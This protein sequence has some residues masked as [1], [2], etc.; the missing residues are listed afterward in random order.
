MAGPI[1]AETNQ[2]PGNSSTYMGY[3]GRL[4]ATPPYK[5][6]MTDLWAANVTIEYAYTNPKPNITNMLY[7]LPAYSLQSVKDCM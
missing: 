1:Y 7:Q 6:Y 4:E 5:G 2:F 3:L